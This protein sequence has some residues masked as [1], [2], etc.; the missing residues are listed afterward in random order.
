MS[1]CHYSTFTSIVSG[2]VADVFIA[3]KAMCCRPSQVSIISVV[4]PQSADLHVYVIPLLGYTITPYK[5]E[6]WTTLK[7][8]SSQVALPQ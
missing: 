5:G 7:A 3:F 1:D 8:V 4:I 2:N 6:I